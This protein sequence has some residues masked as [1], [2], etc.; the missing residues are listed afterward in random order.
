MLVDTVGIEPDRAVALW[1]G[2]SDEWLEPLR[3]RRA[4]RWCASSSSARTA[5]RR[6]IP[7]CWVALGALVGRDDWVATVYT[8]GGTGLDLQLHTHGLEERVTV[9]RN[10]ALT[11]ADYDAADVLLH[12]SR[13]ES[14]PRAVLEALARGLTVVATDVGDVAALVGSCGRVV[15]PADRDAMVAALDQAIDAAR[16]PVPADVAQARQDR[17]PR[18]ATVVR[19]LR[20]LIGSLDA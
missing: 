20:A 8:S 17:C 11:P 15:P 2:V 3:P 6:A 9:V 5:T 12:S 1:S 10:H 16:A 19:D 4:A 7:T 14:L 13:A 18:Q